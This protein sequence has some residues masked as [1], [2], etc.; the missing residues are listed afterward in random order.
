M[1]VTEW[2]AAERATLEGMLG[3]NAGAIAVAYDGCE[4][5]LLPQ[6]RV[7]GMYDW[8]R[9]TPASER[10]DIGGT[11]ELHAKLPIGAEALGPDL[12]RYGSL[13]VMTTIGGQAR[14]QNA[15]TIGGDAACVAATHVVEA[16]S[17]GASTVIAG[18][19]ILRQAGRSETCADPSTTWPRECAAPLQLSLGAI[20]GRAQPEGPAGTVRTEF[21]STDPARH[22]NVLIDDK[23]TCITPCDTFVAPLRTIVMQSGGL[24]REQKLTFTDLPVNQGTVQVT[25]DPRNVPEFT[26][27]LTFTSLGGL[28]I[29]TGIPLVAIGNSREDA[30]MSRAGKITILAGAPAVALG[31]FLLVDS[32]PVVEITPLGSRARA[33]LTP[34]GV[35]GTF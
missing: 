6:C 5:R 31:I 33:F 11:E 12:A 24:P 20:P 1:N 18:G 21:R 29:V 7:P 30:G 27:G 4:L 26:L 28:A 19:G 35:V 17:V 16:V 32:R 15:G 3:S 23:L 25:A 13:S 10:I 2:S 8:Q 14:L 22:W 34:T 9:V